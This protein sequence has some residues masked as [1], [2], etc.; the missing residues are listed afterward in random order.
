VQGVTSRPDSHCVGTPCQPSIV[1]AVHFFGR[2]PVS[3]RC[4]SS[5]LRL[6]RSCR[7][8]TQ[9]NSAFRPARYSLRSLPFKA[10]VIRPTVRPGRFRQSAVLHQSGQLRRRRRYQANSAYRPVRHPQPRWVS[11][12]AARCRSTTSVPGHYIDSAVAR[13]RRRRSAIAR[14]P[15]G[16][17]RTSAAICVTSSTV[18]PLNRPTCYVA[19]CAGLLLQPG[20]CASTLLPVH[21]LSTA[22]CCD[23]FDPAGPRISIVLLTTEPAL[24]RRL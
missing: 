7:R 16:R 17:R 22:V 2:E 9:V 6:T 18:G 13:Q 1:T 11:Q 19:V 8:S 14:P 12:S 20:R 4:Q 23:R 24:N 15:S 10:G 21:Q 5:L 3:C